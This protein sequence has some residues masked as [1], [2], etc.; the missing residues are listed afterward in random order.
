MRTDGKKDKKN[1]GHIREGEYTGNS[2]LRIAARLRRIILRKIAER[3]FAAADDK[4]VERHIFT[5]RKRLKFFYERERQAECF[6]DKFL[7]L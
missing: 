2:D 4:L 1:P 7:S 6:I 5:L 3:I